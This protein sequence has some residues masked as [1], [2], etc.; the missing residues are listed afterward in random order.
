MK[1]R[2]FALMKRR[3]SAR[4]K[5]RLQPRLKRRTAIVAGMAVGLLATAGVALAYFTSTG[6]ATGSASTGTLVVSIAATAGSPASP[7]YPG[8]TG[9]VALQVTN[10]NAR[11]VTLTSVVGD[12]AITATAGCSAPDVT[13]TDQTG[14]AI[15]IP[16]NAANYQVDLPAAAS[17][18]ASSPN[19]C[20]GA[21]F[22]IP[23][24]ITVES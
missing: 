12:G 24:T 15:S 10:P 13:F 4:M 3:A 17:L 6:S 16:A 8:A 5:R 22:S 14:L 1:N 2:E 19:T 20:Q 9:D 11:A 21:T 18:S 23:V 7:L